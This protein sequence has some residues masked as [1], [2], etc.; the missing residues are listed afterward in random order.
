MRRLAISLWILGWVAATGLVLPP[1]AERPRGL[2]WLELS[3]AE[4]GRRIFDGALH[5]GADVVLT[6]KNSLFGLKVT[7]SFAAHAGRL[8]LARVT[9][10]DP[11]GLPPP[12]AT[13]EDLDDLYHTGG[14]FHV[15]GLARPFTRVVFRIGDIG[16][17]QLTV[18]TQTLAFMQEVGFGGIVLMQT[19]KPELRSGGSLREMQ[20]YLWD[21]MEC[22]LF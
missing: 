20:A 18:G 19:R 7:E 21:Q 3:D 6:W 8:D 14:P 17:P 11:R 4:T 10:A 13:P 1:R 5:D 16:D 2:T 9:F 12:V 22:R 15:E